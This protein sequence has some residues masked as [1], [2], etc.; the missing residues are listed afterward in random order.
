MTANFTWVADIPSGV[1]RNHAISRRLYYQSV[2]E[3]VFMDHVD[4]V[5]AFGK[6]MGEV[7]T[8]RRL[9]ALTEP[10]SVVLEESQR[11][12]EDKFTVNINGITLEEVGRAF[13]YTNLAEELTE[14]DLSQAVQRQLKEVMT[15]SLDTL[16]ATA[17]K[18]AQV[19]Y[20]PT[21]LTSRTIT[22]NGTF[23]ATATENMN[24][25]HV[26][27]I[28]DYMFD[29]LKVP[30][31]NGDYVGVFRTLGI[32]GIRRDPAWEEWMKYTNPQ[33]KLNFEAGRMEGIRF[34][35]TNHSQALGKVGTG[36]VLGEGVV[37][38]DDAVS[39][40][41]AHTPELLVAI[42]GD[43]TRSKAVAWYG[44]IAFGVPFNTGN[45]G[46]AKILHVGSA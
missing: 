14:F 4:P 21:G 27:E 29:T 18:T 12:P 7:V 31:I 44:I 46:E 40:A 23:G 13:P 17:F 37:F 26:E 45:A 10:A 1:L 3:S 22:T 39:M 28:R 30:T 8:F 6:N 5:E 16:A 24:L 34:V 2:A 19:K 11:I 35:V 41:E 32:R 33:A 15:L 38:G 36:S 43:F 42:P 20:V 25:Y 9:S